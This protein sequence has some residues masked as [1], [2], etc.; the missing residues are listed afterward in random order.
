MLRAKATFFLTVVFKSKTF[1]ILHI[2][3]KFSVHL[4]GFEH[5]KLHCLPT[6]W[7]DF[8]ACK[9]IPISQCACFWKREIGV[10]I[11]N[12]LHQKKKTFHFMLAATLTCLIFCFCTGLFSQMA[13]DSR[14]FEGYKTILLTISQAVGFKSNS[15][16]LWVESD[17]AMMSSWLQ[18]D[19]F[20]V[21]GSGQKRLC[22][23]AW[24]QE[25]AASTCEMWSE[26][27]SIS[28]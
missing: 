25:A 20:Q 15:W 17:W 11:N 9:N 3:I 13:H 19:N 24:T 22:S 12:R 28:Y 10:A 7:Y 5:E 8:E 16:S 14:V 21:V 27:I 6:C 18:C 4:E 26:Q 23:T 2:L 1:T